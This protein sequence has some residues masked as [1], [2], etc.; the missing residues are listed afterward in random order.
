MVYSVWCH[1]VLSVPMVTNLYTIQCK[2][3]VTMAA[4]YVYWYTLLK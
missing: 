1:W 3:M 4:K 2:Y